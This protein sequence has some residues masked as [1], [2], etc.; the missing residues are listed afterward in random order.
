MK[1]PQFLIDSYRLSQTDILLT[2]VAHPFSVQSVAP[3]TEHQMV[4]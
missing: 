1:L 2:H 3:T 4:E